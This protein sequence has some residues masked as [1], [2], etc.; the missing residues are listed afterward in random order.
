MTTRA[1]EAY[2]VWRDALPARR[3]DIN[4]RVTYQAGYAQ[5]QAD[6]LARIKAGGVVTVYDHEDDVEGHAHYRLP[7][8]EK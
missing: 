1:Q 7:E 5:G 3:R 6:L 2:A 8:G 4:G